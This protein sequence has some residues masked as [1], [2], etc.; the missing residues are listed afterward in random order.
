[1]DPS[2]K[3]ALSSSNIRKF[4][5]PK[6]N[7]NAQSYAELIDW[8]KSKLTE[9]PLTLSLTEAEVL[10]FKES[11][12]DV[13]KYPCHTQAVE[14]GIRLVSEASAAVIGP[15]ARNGF[16]RQRMQARK[17]LGEF[18]SKK[19]YFPKIEASKNK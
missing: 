9:P 4:I 18:I 7:F 11:P 12:F 5:I 2:E 19:D 13:P 1:M 15:E 3:K 6:I 14:R 10:A 16:I 17:E 8:E